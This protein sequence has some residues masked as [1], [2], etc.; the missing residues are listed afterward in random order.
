MKQELRGNI[1]KWLSDDEEGNDE[2]NSTFTLNKENTSPQENSQNSNE[3]NNTRD[4]LKNQL[5]QEVERRAEE[6][7]THISVIFC[8]VVSGVECLNETK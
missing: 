2:L 5:M 4:E 8:I 1:D 3:N 7:S 6:K